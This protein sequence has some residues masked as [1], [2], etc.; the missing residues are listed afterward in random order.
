M[1]YFYR[2][3]CANRGENLIAGIVDE[4]LGNQFQNKE[5]ERHGR[6]SESKSSRFSE[7]AVKYVI[8]KIVKKELTKLERLVHGINYNAL[9][10]FACELDVKASNTTACC[11]WLLSDSCDA[12]LRLHLSTIIWSEYS[13]RWWRRDNWCTITTICRMRRSVLQRCTSTA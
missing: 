5:F 6:Y 7:N 2:R 3:A 4:N 1:Q 10:C 9:K 13:I 8:P 11:R 12:V